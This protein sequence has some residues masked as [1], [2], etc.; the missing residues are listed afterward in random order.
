MTNWRFWERKQTEV[1]K[2]L[3]NALL[4]MRMNEAGQTSGSPNHIDAARA[5]FLAERLASSGYR[6]ER[7]VDR[8]PTNL[9]SNGQIITYGKM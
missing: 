1:E 6:L 9:A 3:T 5:S 4:S 2:A 7:F 8:E